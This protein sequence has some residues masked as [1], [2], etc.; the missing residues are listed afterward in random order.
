MEFIHSSLINDSSIEE[1]QS[2]RRSSKTN[3][4][5]YFLIINQVQSNGHVTELLIKYTSN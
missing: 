2:V 5:E 3:D 1:L 4:D